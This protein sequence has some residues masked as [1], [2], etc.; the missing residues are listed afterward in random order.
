MFVATL[1]TV[2]CTPGITE[3]L[4]SVTTP[5]ILP[6]PAEAW[7]KSMELEAENSAAA[8]KG[9]HKNFE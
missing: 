4:G 6:V 8:R 3:P 2:T 9:S 5:E 7:A 1:R